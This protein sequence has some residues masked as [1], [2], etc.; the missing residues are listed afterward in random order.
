MC[1]RCHS[2][3]RV[4]L[5]RRTA[6][7]WLK[8]INFHVGQWPTLE[9]QDGSRDIQW[10]EI[11]TTQLPAELAN[12][13]PLNSAAWQ[14]WRDRPH[15]ALAGNWIFHGHTPGRGDYYGTA[16]IRRVAGDEYRVRYELH[17]SNG[18]V[19]NDSSNA[20]VYTGYQWRGTGTLGGK[21][22]QEV[23]FASEDG[24]QISGRWSFYYTHLG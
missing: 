10:W 3:A 19:F 8:L 15:A 23:Y 14:N 17:D 4:A 21:P 20:I 7:E 13:F 1:G 11:A 6:A 18:A 9:F 24:S 22:V 5:Q 16:N 2:L 12:L